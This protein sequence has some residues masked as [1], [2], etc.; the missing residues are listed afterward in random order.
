MFPVAAVVVVVVV[1]AGSGGPPSL[2][3]RIQGKSTW[4]AEAAAGCSWDDGRACVLDS[5]PR[6]VPFHSLLI[7]FFLERKR[8]PASDWTGNP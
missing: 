3:T 4:L 2:E 5:P 6:S 8:G 1:V 7:S